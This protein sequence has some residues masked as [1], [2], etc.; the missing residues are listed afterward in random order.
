MFF[1]IGVF[2]CYYVWGSCCLLCIV[3]IVVICMSVYIL[4]VFWGVRDILNARAIYLQIE[5]AWA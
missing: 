3:C 2:C 5:E 4:G 1:F